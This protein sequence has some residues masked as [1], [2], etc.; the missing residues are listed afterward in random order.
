MTTK[1]LEANILFYDGPP[2]R[3]KDG[4]II[5]PSTDSGCG[6]CMFPIIILVILG[7]VWFLIRYF[8]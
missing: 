2:Q 4:N 1:D 5:P 6:C 3:D 7:I 8:F